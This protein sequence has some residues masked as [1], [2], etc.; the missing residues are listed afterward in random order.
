MDSTLRE[1]VPSDVGDISIYIDM[2]LPTSESVFWNTHPP[3]VYI[4]T[5]PFLR[6]FQKSFLPLV[7]LFKLKSF[8]SIESQVFSS[9][10]R[11]NW[12]KQFPIAVLFLENTYDRAGKCLL[13]AARGV[14]AEIRVWHVN[15]CDDGVTLDDLD[16][17]HV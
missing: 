12:L 6:I 14:A 11:K 7:S 1:N 4:F 13:G 10:N 17:A 8:S 15:V 16:A 2:Y 9:N 5:C 3:L